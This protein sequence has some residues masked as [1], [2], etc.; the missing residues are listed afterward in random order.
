MS[1]S[2]TILWGSL[3]VL[4][5]AS[6]G[7]ERIAGPDGT[8]AVVSTDAAAAALAFLQVSAG[9]E[10][11]CGLTSDNRAYCWGRNSSGQ[12][13]DGT[14]AERL[15]PVPVA[16]SR[17]FRQI[18]ASV[19]S[20]CAVTTD[21]RAYCWGENELGQL[22]DGTTSRRLTP[23]A[24]A[25]GR[26]FRQVSSTFQHACALAST[27]G[28]I[29]CW[30]DNSDGQL[31][32]G[33]RTGPQ[34]GNFGPYSS[35]PVRVAGTLVFRQ[36]SVGNYH[37]CAVTTDD[38]AWCWGFNRQGQVGDS[39]SV[40]RRLKPTRVS[41]G[42]AFRQIDADREHTCAV[43]TGNQAYCWGNGLF[44]QLGITVLAKRSYPAA[45]SGGHQFRRITAGEFH[46]C[47]ETPSDRTYCWGNNGTGQVG[48]GTDVN[49]P[50]PVQVVGGHLFA[51]VSAGGFHTCARTEAGAAY[52]WG[53][54]FAGQLGNGVA[55]NSLTPSA[56]AGAM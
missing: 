14:T 30:G 5:G 26:L 1:R 56:V 53:R 37:S 4:A 51:Q 52:C 31:G 36:V 8:S 19:N 38:R 42:H 28:R 41:G 34:T 16:G 46:T 9:H 33:S 48:D 10:H 7:G 29:F 25:G 6:C 13:G 21:Y 12:L 24:V 17:R 50:A 3:L 39:S 15:I 55:A 47:A 11:S 20:T 23:V 32:I 54:G 35:T 27:G 2:S 45:V 18:S 40:W 22:G 44:G 43:T 49:R